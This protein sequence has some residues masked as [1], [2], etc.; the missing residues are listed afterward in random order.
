MMPAKAKT[1]P[2]LRVSVAPAPAESQP[3][4]LAVSEREAAQMLSIGERTLRGLR[5]AGKVHFTRVG[6]RVVY[7]VVDLDTLLQR[8]KEG[9]DA[10]P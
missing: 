6:R 8:A 7:R 10:P 5:N 9:G 2:I 1:P 4:K 3:A